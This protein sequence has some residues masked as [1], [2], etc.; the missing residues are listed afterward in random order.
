MIQTVCVQAI[1]TWKKHPKFQEDI[2]NVK[3]F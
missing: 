2:G 3:M 1:N